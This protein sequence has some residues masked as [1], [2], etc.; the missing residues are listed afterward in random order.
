MFES[1][2]IHMVYLSHDINKAK[3]QFRYG[4]LKYNAVYFRT[5]I[6]KISVNSVYVVFP[7]ILH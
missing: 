1:M 4:L 3:I 2:Y 6:K 5:Q 7:D